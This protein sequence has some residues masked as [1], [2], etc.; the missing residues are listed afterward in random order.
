M[1]NPK[2]I[3]LIEENYSDRLALCE[4]LENRG[5]NVI[6]LHSNSEALLK[7]EECHCGFV[8]VTFESHGMPCADFIAGV[9]DKYPDIDLLVLSESV[10]VDDAVS[11]M[12][13]GAL[14]YI[15]KPLAPEQLFLFT[16]KAFDKKNKS[17][18]KCNRP[19][20]GKKD[21]AVI[22]TE[23]KEMKAL[24]LLIEK[25]ADSTASVL[26]QGESGTGKEL[27]AK[28]VHEKSQRKNGPFVAVNCAAL[29]E[30][31]LESELFGHEKGAFTGAIA[32]KPGKFE[33]AAKGTILL[34]EI[35][36][37][38]WHLQAKLL[39]VIQ[40]RE[41]DR[42][43]GSTPVK[44][45][46]RIVATTNRDIKEAV[47]KGDFR[48]D[49]YYRLNVIPV[50]I[51]SLRE[52]WDDIAPLSDYFIKKFNL[53]DG[54]NVKSL[55]K[56]ALELLSGLPLKGNVRELENI[57]QRAVLLS[58]G[59]VISAANLFIEDM[60]AEDTA[61]FIPRPGLSDDILASPL[62]EVERKMIFH[63]LEKTGGNRTHAAKILEIS[64]RTLRNKL[65]EYKDKNTM[66]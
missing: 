1:V 50:V 35:T 28:Y 65:N 60:K 41:V 36:E 13:S 23:N 48:E 44:I 39:R 62:K 59:D 56:E 58:S 55:T 7:I 54:R 61:D 42:L 5:C 32:R 8:I 51:P 26:I 22:I 37:M 3:L 31:L 18:D 46:V 25:I 10:S 47:A 49:L 53:I 45:D 11:V 52:R 4:M 24:L 9:K 33:L 43:G 12:K 21:Q 14:D 29:P 38:Q 19:V 64:V 34:D 20:A 6:T 66:V 2:N 17:S 57:I 30:N 15:V 63:T 16:D 27:F 40:E